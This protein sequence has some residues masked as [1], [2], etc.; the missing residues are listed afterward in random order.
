MLLV[1]YTAGYF[2]LNLQILSPY[3]EQALVYPFGYFVTGD[4]S[5]ILGLTVQ[6]G[7]VLGLGLL[8]GLLTFMK[9]PKL[10]SD[11]AMK[12]LL[13]FVVLSYAGIAAIDRKSTRL[14]SSHANISYA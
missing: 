5:L 10:E 4:L 11:L 14:N 12:W 9:Q 6:L 3:L 13:V 8:T 1:F 7:L 2:I